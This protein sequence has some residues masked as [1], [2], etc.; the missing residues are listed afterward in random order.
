MHYSSSKVKQT[1]EIREPKTPPPSEQDQEPHP[2]RSGMTFVLTL[3]AIGL[4]TV[5]ATW[6]QNPRHEEYIGHLRALSRTVTSDRHARIEKYLVIEGQKVEPGEPL[7]VLTD[8]RVEEA[9]LE[10]QRRI[11]HLGAELTQTRAKAAVELQWRL[12]ELEREIFE[13]RLKS[14]NYLQKQMTHQVEQIARREVMEQLQKP[15]SERRPLGEILQIH[16]QE[17]PIN[18]QMKIEARLKIH[19]INNALEVAAAQV[20]LCDIRIAELQQLQKELPEKLRQ[21]TGINIVETRLAEA[22]QKLKQQ[23][24]EKNLLTLHAEQPGTVGVFKQQ[25]GDYLH[26][27]QPILDI[28]DQE[29]RFLSVRIPSTDLDKFEQG[30]VVHLEFP[31]GTDREGRVIE[32]PPQTLPIVA[33]GQESLDGVTQVSVHIEQAGRIWPV[34]PFGTAVKVRRAE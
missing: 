16:R 32:I 13:T 10:T 19:K 33:G 5:V 15:A 21:S 27:T 3:M 2:R 29:H 7:V 11:E 24:Q 9:R 12:E 30:A 23:E 34:V 28:L 22:K 25:P 8:P 6:T 14:A 31:G 17:P 1:S 4:G 20:E 26:Q 18:N